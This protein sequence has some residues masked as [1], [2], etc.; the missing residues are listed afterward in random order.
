MYS[1]IAP[2]AAAR[3]NFSS[4]RRKIV[5]VSVPHK[6]RDVATMTSSTG[7]RESGELLMT[8]R[9]SAV[10]VWCSS[11]S[12]FSSSSRALSI[13]TT[14]LCAFASSR[15][16][17]ADRSWCSSSAILRLRSATTSVGSAVIPSNP[18]SGCLA[19]RDTISNQISLFAGFGSPLHAC[20]AV[21]DY[22]IPH[23]CRPAPQAKISLSVSMPAIWTAASTS[24]SWLRAS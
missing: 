17:T 9:I 20:P 4:L 13:A 15:S 19:A 18:F 10:A 12:L 16:A 22:P 7:C 6:C 14:A 8:F 11:A 5:E 1:G 21:P 3:W 23:A 2:D 24:R